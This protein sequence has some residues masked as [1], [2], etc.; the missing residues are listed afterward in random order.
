M[1]LATVFTMQAYA[2]SNGCPVNIDFEKGNYTNWYFYTGT[3]CPANANTLSGPVANRHVLTNNITSVDPYGLFPIVAPGGG[4][5]SL[6][7]GNNLTGAQSER[8]RYYLRVPSGTTKY[9]AIYRYAVVFQDPGH[10]PADQPNFKVKAT[11][12]ATGQAIPCNDF[13]YIASSSIPGFQTSTVSSDVLFKPW[14]TASIDL[15]DYSGRTI[16]LDFISG[17][18]G[19]GAHFGYGYIDMDCGTFQ[20]YKL[21]CG[22]NTQSVLVEGPPGYASYQWM[23]ETFTTTYGTN[24]NLYTATPPKTTTYAVVLTPYQ[25]LGCTDT[26]F[27]TVAIFDP[28]V[29]GDT[30][31]C[32]DNQSIQLKADVE[33]DDAP[34]TYKWEPAIGLSCTNCQYPVASPT[35]STNYWVTVT[36]KSGCIQTDTVKIGIGKEVSADIKPLTDTVCQYNTLP[37]TN[38]GINPLNEVYHYWTLSP[39]GKVLDGQLTPNATAS[40]NTDGT[41]AVYLKVVNQAC[42]SF[43][44]AYV[45]A[46]PSAEARFATYNHVCIGDTISLHPL[47]QDATYHWTIDEIKIDNTQYQDPIKLSW[48]TLGRK[49]VSL[50]VTSPNGC[51]P[52]VHDTMV[53]VHEFPRAQI[54]IEGNYVCY[55]DTIG[56]RTPACENCRYEWKPVN[57]MQRNNLSTVN[58]IVN[59][60]SFLSVKTTTEWGCA[61]SDSAYIAPV[62]CCEISMPDA[63]TPNGDGRN[64]VFRIVSEGF[65]QVHSFIVF[66][67]WGQRIFETSAQNVGWDGTFKG[68]K[69]DPGTYSYYIKYKCTD[70]AKDFFEQKG[71]FILLR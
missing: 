69:Q 2:Q 44:T 64:D 55:D 5:Y 31:L 34:F 15:S 43:D 27:T 10:S 9:I 6:K 41:H 42:E 20:T 33:A 61:T 4:V 11:D 13:S 39:N 12:S 53:N 38:V 19:Q 25:G 7:L 8:A 63:F 59:R 58:A 22:T 56:L 65:Q 16:A 51:I 50:S 23:D 49:K 48:N 47:Q 24:Q 62:H 67:R 21:I 29:T 45:F 18:C 60:E 54:V 3:C 30:V 26:F 35:V 17:D 46:K 37:L 66:N 40:W 14:S 28:E 57:F 32:G 52:P 71:N 68:T 1:L 36:G 70:R